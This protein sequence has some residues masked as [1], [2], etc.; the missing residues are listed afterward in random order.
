[1]KLKSIIWGYVSLVVITVLIAVVLTDFNFPVYIS[2]FLNISCIYI[3]VCLVITAVATGADWAKPI[4]KS[5]EMV[6]FEKIFVLSAIVLWPV[7]ITLD[8]Y[9]YF[10]EI[11]SP[12][13]A[14]IL[15]AISVGI[16]IKFCEIE[17]ILMGEEFY[18]H[19]LGYISLGLLTLIFSL[20]ELVNP[21]SESAWPTSLAKMGLAFG[22]SFLF[23]LF[24]NYIDT[25]VGKISPQDSPT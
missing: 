23:G 9:N 17:W 5:K 18:K 25:L 1:M 15:L 21:V 24:S 11:W 7:C 19:R 3:L 10:G 13:I 22:V 4:T 14:S 16:L 12:I 2:I 8:V 6:R 20:W